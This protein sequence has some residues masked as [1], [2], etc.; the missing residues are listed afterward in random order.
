[1]FQASSQI[2]P[3]SFRELH[4]EQKISTQWLSCPSIC[5]IHVGRV[6]LG[7]SLL[8]ALPHPTIDCENFVLNLFGIF[9]ADDLFEIFL[10]FVVHVRSMVY[11]TITDTIPYSPDDI[12]KRFPD[13]FDHKFNVVLLTKLDSMWTNRTEVMP[14]HSGEQAGERE[15]GSEGGREEGEREINASSCLHWTILVTHWCSIW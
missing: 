8:T 12:T 13:W 1:M 3:D 4:K 14:W 15:K 5:C 2:S 6:W 7:W 11:Y 9:V 10:I